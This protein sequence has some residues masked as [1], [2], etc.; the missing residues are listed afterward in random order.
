MTSSQTR[1]RDGEE[2]SSK[3][4]WYPREFSWAYPETSDEIPLVE[5][6]TH[7]DTVETAFELVAAVTEVSPEAQVNAWDSL[8]RAA[9]DYVN[10]IKYPDMRPVGKGIVG[11]PVEAQR[12]WFC[13]THGWASEKE[14]CYF[15]EF[16]RRS[17]NPW[18]RLGK[19][20]R[21]RRDCRIVPKVMFSPEAFE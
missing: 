21:L 18:K 6:R 2:R 12:V 7:P 14:Y 20:R 15:P 8:R 16:F 9:G 11:D 5:M 4:T 17:I 13:E 3:R 1:S 10:L 19:L